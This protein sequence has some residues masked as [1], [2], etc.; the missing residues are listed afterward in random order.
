MK[1]PQRLFTIIFM[2]MLLIAFVYFLSGSKLEGF[3]D[4]SLDINN[5]LATEPPVLLQGTY[6]IT[7]KNGLS[8][9][10][11]SDI[12]WWYP[13]FKVGSYAQITNNIKNTLRPSNG[14]CM[15]ASMCGALYEEQ[16][17]GSN[18]VYALPPVRDSN[19]VRIGYFTSDTRDLVLPFKP[20][21]VL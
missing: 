1:Q 5:L 9:N 3:S 16:Y 14:T 10:G 18:H 2:V 13:T 6:P 4:Y 20:T 19:G 15:P 12:W 21:I 7:G 11:A 8:D 17:M